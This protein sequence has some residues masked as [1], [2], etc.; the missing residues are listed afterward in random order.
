MKHCPRPGCSHARAFG[1]SHLSTISAGRMAALV[2]L[3]SAV[4]LALLAGPGAGRSAAASAAPPA[5]VSAQGLFTRPLGEA[6]SPLGHYRM[7][8]SLADGSQNRLLAEIQVDAVTA[9]GGPW[10][11]HAIP[12]PALYLSDLG[13]VA[14]LETFDPPEIPGTLRIYDLG[15]RQFR[16]GY[17]DWRLLAACGRCH[18]SGLGVRGLGCIA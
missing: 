5:S 9:A 4:S 13:R 18:R 8:Y 15:G 17:F 11:L 16:S 1:A 12:G 14:A 2:L 6:Y 3:F 7:R 10:T